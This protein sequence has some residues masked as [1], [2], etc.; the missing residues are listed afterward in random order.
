LTISVQNAPPVESFRRR[1]LARTANSPIA[2][3]NATTPDQD[4]RIRTSWDDNS[5]LWAEAVRR[6][7]IRSRGA[8]TDAAIFDAVARLSPA[9]VLDIGCGEGWLARRLTRDLGCR[10]VGVDGS[11]DLVRLAREADP[12]GDYRLADYDAVAADPALLG[13]PFD[14]VAANFA[15]LAEDVT[16]L[17]RALLDAAPRGALVVQTVHPWSAC[18]VAPYRDGWR[19]ETFSGFG[20]GSWRPMPW[21]FRTLESWHAAL[22]S[23]GWRIEALREPIDPDSGRPLSLLMSCTPSRPASSPLTAG[24]GPSRG[25]NI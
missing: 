17:L 4:D 23:A 7:A 21:F 24:S 14:A 9:S 5:A 19:E 2:R 10:T 25:R 8:G 3:P 16:G 15:L 20:A 11:A 6:N 1:A 13:G 12:Q 18:G 22:A